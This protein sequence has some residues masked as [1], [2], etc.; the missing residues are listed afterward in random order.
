ME[1]TYSLT[2]GGN[3]S[4][5]LVFK[6]NPETRLFNHNKYYDLANIQ[7]NKAT[8]IIRSAWYASAAHA[9]NK[10]TYKIT[11]DSL[12][13]DQGISYLLN[14]KTNGKIAT[15]E[16]YSIK[17]DSTIVNRRIIESSKRLWKKFENSL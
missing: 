14:A 16:F 2:A 10:E 3:N 7:F 13:F 15:M 8:R 12:T 11:G 6:F 17:G 5:N 1:V 9:Q 4:E